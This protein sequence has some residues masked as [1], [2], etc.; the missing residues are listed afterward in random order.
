M[1]TFA[2]LWILWLA[3]LPLIVRWLAPPRLLVRPAVRVPF[4]PRIV[5]AGGKTSRSFGRRRVAAGG[6]L[7]RVAAGPG[8]TGASPM[9]RTADRAVPSHARPAAAGGPVGFHGSAGFHQTRPA[10]RS[11]G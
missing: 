10:R 7:G 4:L 11:I 9:A 1:L 3:P 2:H 5:A 8:G 6:A